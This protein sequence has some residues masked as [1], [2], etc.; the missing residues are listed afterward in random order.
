M[1]Q[2]LTQIAENSV[3]LYNRCH[4]YHYTAVITGDGSDT[5]TL[6]LPFAPD[7]VQIIC[8]D[9]RI[10]LRNNTVMFYTADLSSLGFAGAV[11]TSIR[12]GKL[13]SSAMTVESLNARVHRAED[14]TVT[15][16]CVS[17]DVYGPDLTY[18][19]VATKL[20]DKTYRQRYEEFVEG[21]TGSGTA[22]V[23]KKKVCEA[24]TAEEWAA[25]TATRPGW[26]FEEV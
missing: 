8:T 7:T 9:P 26:T 20:T 2:K 16:N 18:K 4:K 22:Q 11:H 12:D 17:G 25:L 6:P 14:G 23:C 10:M 19:V 13:A 1:E 24:F 5:L 21:L 15:I 3:E